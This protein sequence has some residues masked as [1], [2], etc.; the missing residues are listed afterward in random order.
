MT[1]FNDEEMIEFIRRNKE[2]V[3]ELLKDEKVF[4]ED[5]AGEAKN[6]AEKAAEK[7]KEKVSHGK[8]R[9]EE[10]AKDIYKA[11]MN[12]EAHRHFVRMGLELFMGLSAIMEKM[13][14]PKPIREFREDLE[15]SREG[16]QKEFCK[17]NK[18]CAA[19]KSADD[20]I[21]RIEID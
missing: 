1:E 21:E 4:A 3:A 10:T 2:R 7:V 20:G 14:M 6:S 19:K 18:N 13:P 11:I 12:P 17:T 5:L 8:E 16:V 9:A 15:E